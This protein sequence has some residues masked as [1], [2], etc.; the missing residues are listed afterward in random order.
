MSEGLAKQMTSEEQRVCHR[1]EIEKDITAFYKYSKSGK[2]KSI[3]AN[4]ENHNKSK[5]ELFKCEICSIEIRKANKKTHEKSNHH[6][7]CYFWN[8]QYS[9]KLPSHKCRAATMS[10]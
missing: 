1:C 3:C 5:Y 7:Q 9:L 8:K 10:A 2:Y 4:C 6:L